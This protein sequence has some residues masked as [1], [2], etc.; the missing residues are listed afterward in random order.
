MSI[1]KKDIEKLLGYEI[2]R[3]K[4][5]SIYDENDKWEGISIHVWPK[6]NIESIERNK[7]IKKII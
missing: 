5:E 2:N 1:L 4:V 3:F 6:E 7:T